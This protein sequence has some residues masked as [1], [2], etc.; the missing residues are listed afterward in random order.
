MSYCPKCGNEVDETMTFCPICGAPLKYAATSQ[1]PPTQPNRNEENEKSEKEKKKNH[2]S[3]KGTKHEKD[4]HGFIGYLMGGSILIT[5]GI[6]ALLDL[7]GSSLSSSQDLS[8]MLL[9]IGAII[10]IGAVYRA[11]NARKLAATTGY[12]SQP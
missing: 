9:T 1:T 5:I 11:L 3:E 10:I 2:H 8:A 4:E 6:F 12:I 7:T